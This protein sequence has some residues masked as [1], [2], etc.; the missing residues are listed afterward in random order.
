MVDRGTCH[1]VIKAQNVQKFGGVLA[2]VVDNKGMENVNTIVMAD[3]GKGESVN[4][5]TF[6][7]SMIDGDK[8]KEVIHSSEEAAAEENTSGKRMDWKNM[9][10][11]QA[12]LNLMSKT[13]K[14]VQVDLWYTG[15]SELYDAKIKL[16][17]YAKM[18]DLF[19]NQVK[20]QP[21]TMVH[22]CVYCQPEIKRQ[23]ILDGKYCPT[24][25]RKAAT[26]NAF[27]EANIQ[28]SNLIMQSIREQCVY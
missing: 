22:T 2:L 16:D 23:C 26:G 12:E 13:D 10:V 17:Q 7:I 27:E 18:S 19:G 9:V 3:D 8:L 1:F 15:A 24:L 21:R 14:P 4:I 11:M 25:S 5:P 6:L 28:P 20:F